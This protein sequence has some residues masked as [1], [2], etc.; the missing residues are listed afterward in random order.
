MAFDGSTAQEIEGQ[1]NPALER[2]RAW[3]VKSK[4]KFAPHKTNALLITNKLKY[5]TPRLVM[6]GIEVGFAEE[7][8]LL[9]VTIDNKL[10]FNSHI[11]NVC[12]K[13]AGIY[14][15]LTKAAK[16]SW[17]LHPEVVKT[18]YVATIEPVILYAAS[19]WAPAAEKLTTRKKF[20]VIQRGIAQ[21]QCGAYR[22]VSLNAA[23]LLAGM[24]PLDLRVRE[25]ALL[26]E[27]KRGANLPQLGDREIERRGSALETPHPAE[28]TSIEF[29][30]LADQDALNKNEQY[31]TRIYTD[32]SKIG[33]RVGAALSIWQGDAETRA[34]K[35]A[36]SDY[37][38]VY[39]AE[40]LALQE[41]TSV[42]LNSA[43]SSFGVYSDSR[44]ALQTI[45][46]HRCLHPLA[47]ATRENLTSISLQGKELSLFWI[48][49]HAGLDGNE[50]ADQLAKEAA[51]AS[52]RRPNYDLCPV[53][54]IK[55]I[56]RKDS[57]DVWNRRYVEGT[58]ASTTKLFFPNVVEAYGVVRKMV[59]RGIITQILTGHGGFSEYLNRFK[60]KE[61]PS[62]SCEPGVPETIAHLLLE[63]PQYGVQRF[64][65]ENKIDIKLTKDNI[66]D[67]M[68]G[69]NRERFI[70]YC[71]E[72]ASKTIVKNKN[73]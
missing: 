38:S 26:Y 27:A 2:V 10:T 5:D 16:V 58:T 73:R 56:L 29:G 17:G 46:N 32:G 33:G 7:V 47:I 34:V 50:R 45:S 31:T 12:R 54:H 52:K 22:T 9:G 70:K 14:K 63:C 60:C 21:K 62:C 71:I 57:L 25:A 4:L 1:A 30:I 43:G 51:V 49:A 41:A 24:L 44:A 3:G 15:Q 64:D 67:I 11:T 42:A 68:M 69:K 23:L 39:Q 65:L 53:S 37:C 8:K 19:V 18:I 72:V 55:R 28:Q 20:E 35:L 13:A 6:G 36:L 40:L 59:P 61:N 48:K 66:R